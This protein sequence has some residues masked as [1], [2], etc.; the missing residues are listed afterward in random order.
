MTLLL[1]IVQALDLLKTCVCNRMMEMAQRAWIAELESD[2]AKLQLELEQ[3]RQALVK[4][5][6]AQSSLSTDQ[7][8]L[9]RECTGL[10]TAVNVLKQKKI[11]VMSDCEAAKQKKF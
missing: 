11:Q 10:H 6:A 3:A 1:G 5:D 9:E 2:N 4:A 8:R 7:E